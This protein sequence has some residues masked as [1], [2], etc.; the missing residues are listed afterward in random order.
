MKPEAPLKHVKVGQ[1]EQAQTYEGVM[2]TLRRLQ[3]LWFDGH[4]L[5]DAAFVLRIWP[6]V[7]W[8]SSAALIGQA[9]R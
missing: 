1:A 7:P 4:S 3:S 5:K 6:T 2:T 9:N 8:G